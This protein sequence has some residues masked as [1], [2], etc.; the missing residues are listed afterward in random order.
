MVEREK[1]VDKIRKLKAKAEGTENP[2][3]ADAF[4]AKVVRMME[5]HAVEESE[6]KTQLAR[7]GPTCFE[8][9]MRYACGWQRMMYKEIC[10]S[11]G[12]FYVYTRGTER[13]KTYGLEDR[14]KAS[15]SCHEDV[16]MQIVRYARILFPGDRKKQ[17]RA[18]SGLGIGVAHRI[19]T[20]R[21]SSKSSGKALI[22]N[23]EAEARKYAFSCNPN[24]VATKARYSDTAEFG[25]GYH[26]A[27][28]IQVHGQVTNE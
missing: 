10:G 25:V 21:A 26:N 16:F 4:M 17:R 20:I 23:D 8:W 1:L 11:M 27:G 7:L 24:T 13:V 15:V 19:S 3:E 28:A 14:V 6:L 12:C 9:N 2:A 22:L 5:E 18:E